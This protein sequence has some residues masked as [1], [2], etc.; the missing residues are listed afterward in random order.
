MKAKIIVKGIIHNKRLGKILLVQ[1][2]SSDP[3]GAGTWENSGGNVEQGEQPEEAVK[4]EIQ[5]ETGITAIQ[6]ERI[7]Y[8]T[9]LDCK[10]P[11]L[12]I[13]Y[14]CATQTEAVILSDE[15]QAFFWA[16][17]EDCVSMLPKAITDDFEKNNIF[18]YLWGIT[19]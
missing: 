4:R 13:A 5:E 15:H 7:A 1:R 3:I 14:L 11:C 12:I 6:I 8:L 9:L 10:E 19:D 18:E 17:K 16:N 2:S